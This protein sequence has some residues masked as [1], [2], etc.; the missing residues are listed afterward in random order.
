MNHSNNSNLLHSLLRNNLPSL[1]MTSWVTL[2]NSITRVSWHSWNSSYMNMIIAPLALSHSPEMLLV[3]SFW[4]TFK[5]MY[6]V[7]R[8][9]LTTFSW[10]KASWTKTPQSWN[11]HLLKINAKNKWSNDLKQRLLRNPRK[12]LRVSLKTG[13]PGSWQMTSWI[14]WIVSSWESWSSHSKVC[15]NNKS[16][17]STTSSHRWSDKD[18]S[19]GRKQDRLPVKLL[20]WLN[21]RLINRREIYHIN[22]KPCPPP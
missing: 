9:L 6:R 1:T 4:K 3:S 8:W 5:T 13:Y 7:G 17:S 20:H 18:P 16:R 11:P 15:C 22:R 21:L 10:V 14:I 2:T 19:R 12:N